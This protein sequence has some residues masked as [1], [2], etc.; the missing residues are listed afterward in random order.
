MEYIDELRDKIKNN[1]NLSEEFKCNLGTLTDTIVTVLPEYDYSNLSNVLSNLDIVMD[2]E[3][4]SYSKYDKNNNVIKLN[5]D[6][7]FNDR[8]DLQHLMLNELLLRSSTLDNEALEG[9]NIGLTEAI[10]S[11]MNTD[12]S[13]VKLNPLEYTLTSLFSKV[14]DGKILMNNYFNGDISNI[15]FELESKGINNEDFVGLLSD[16][17]KVRTNDSSFVDAELLLIEMYQKKVDFELKNNSITYDDISNKFDDFS[18][19]LIQKRSELISIYPHYDFS[20]LNGFEK[21]NEALTNA[22]VKVEEK[23]EEKTK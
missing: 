19:L 18:E 3:L 20:N 7:I 11:T 9:F 6:K 5:I 21:V 13:M 1:S 16:F 12:E 14:V 15:A 22:V 8:I 17:N 4:E 10:S 2:N 23:E